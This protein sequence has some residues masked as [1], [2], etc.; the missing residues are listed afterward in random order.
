MEEA[1]VGCSPASP[2]S[3]IFVDL[4]DFKVV[5]DS[6]G[7]G[8]GDRLLVGVAERLRSSAPADSLVARLAGDEFA[9]LCG[10]RASD[11]PALA[12]KI[13]DFIALPIRLGDQSIRVSASVGYVSTTS[14][15][16]DAETLIAAADQSMYVS[17]RS[18][19]GEGLD[20][21]TASA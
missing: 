6:L 9:V 18:K 7:H 8:M 20:V 21:R 1:L 12:S 5:N 4:D 2:V 10:A 15:A 17:K 3:V 19:R 11:L 14:P 16:G 13:Q